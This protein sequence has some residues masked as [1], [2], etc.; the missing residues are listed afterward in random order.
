ME[1][2]LLV[3]G[4]IFIVLCF[5]GIGG[6]VMMWAWNLVMPTLF[7]LPMITFWQGVAINFL[8]GAITRVITVKG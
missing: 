5:L 6:V 7:H 3:L 1:K 2:A 8:L 4:V